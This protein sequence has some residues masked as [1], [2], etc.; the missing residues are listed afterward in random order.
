MQKN[1]LF[2][3]CMVLSIHGN[4]LL[5]KETQ[6]KKRGSHNSRTNS[7]KSELEIAPKTT[8]DIIEQSRIYPPV[9]FLPLQTQATPAIFELPQPTSTPSKDQNLDLFSYF[10]RPINFSKEGITHYFKYTYNH[11]NYTQYLPYSFSHMIEFLEFGQ[12]H[13]QSEVYAKSIIKLFLQKIK[14]CDFINS[15]NMI[16]AMPKI[17]DALAPYVEKKEASFLDELQKSLKARFSNIFS[18]YFSYFQKSPDAFLDAL[19]EQIAKKTN[20]VQTQQHVEVEQIKKDVQRFLETCMNKLIWSPTDG[21]EAWVSINEL[22]TK[23]EMFL[24]RKLLSDVDALDDICWSLL[25]RFAY[26][27]EV[28]ADEIPEDVFVKI[29]HD[30]YNEKLILL[31]IDEQ[32]ELITGKKDFLLKKIKLY[33]PQALPKSAKEYKIFAAQTVLESAQ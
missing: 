26:F 10:L 5:A 14:G 21:Y 33:C 3:L 9:E 15:Y 20:E 29:V 11:D 22:A 6:P 7:T 12:E 13:E 19:S 2:L 30:I 1:H 27:I 28:S 18:T 17:A 24:D 25:H 32:E 4:L 31:A 8:E 16:T 23:A